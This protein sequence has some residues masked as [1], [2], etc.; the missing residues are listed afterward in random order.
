[1]PKP[2]PIPFPMLSPLSICIMHQEFCRGVSNFLPTV[3]QWGGTNVSKNSTKNSLKHPR[4]KGRQR[5]S[6]VQHNKRRKQNPNTGI[7]KGT[8]AVTSF[9]IALGVFLV[10]TALAPVK[11]PLSI[12]FPS[13]SSTSSRGMSP[14]LGLSTQP[15][16]HPLLPWVPWQQPTSAGNVAR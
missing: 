4:A 13:I 14:S 11:F 1:M 8:L 7:S 15:V 3:H 6:G 10:W 2:C 5:T 16:A 9:F 12:S